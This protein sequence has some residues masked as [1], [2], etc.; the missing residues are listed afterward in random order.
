MNCQASNANDFFFRNSH[1]LE[2]LWYLHY[3]FQVQERLW[4]WQIKLQ[5]DYITQLAWERLRIPQDATM[6][7]P[8]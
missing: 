7:Q 2:Y 4:S 8:R 3:C 1:F 6:T 5:S